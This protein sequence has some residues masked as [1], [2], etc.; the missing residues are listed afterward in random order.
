MC[1]VF[2][3]PRCRTYGHRGTG[4]SLLI[5]SSCVL[6]NPIPTKA[7]KL[8]SR[9]HNG[10]VQKI[11]LERATPESEDGPSHFSPVLSCLKASLMPASWMRPKMS[12][13]SF[14]RP[15]NQ[16]STTPP[17]SGISVAPISFAK[18]SLEAPLPI[19][20]NW[21]APAIMAID[22]REVNVTKGNH[23]RSSLLSQLATPG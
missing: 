23:R 3:C 15:S 18:S 22:G 5:S 14:R 8:G 2:E 19:A 6:G 20:N 9:T 10:S 21:S 12:L 11:A 1:K 4:R 13:S 17:A 16:K 7:K